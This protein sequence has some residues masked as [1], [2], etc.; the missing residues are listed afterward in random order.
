MLLQET[1]ER[2]THPLDV[3]M[4]HLYL[5]MIVEGLRS[6]LQSKHAT[7]RLD[8]EVGEFILTDPRNFTENGESTREFASALM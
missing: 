7:K 8:N 1:M 4:N 5:W 3:P 6:G 2:Y